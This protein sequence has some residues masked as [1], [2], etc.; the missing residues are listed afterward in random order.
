MGI[1]VEKRTT[2]LVSVLPTKLG[3]FKKFEFSKPSSLSKRTVAIRK[4][5]AGGKDS[6][7]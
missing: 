1:V 2:C 3:L 6:D 5:F 7:D 4:A